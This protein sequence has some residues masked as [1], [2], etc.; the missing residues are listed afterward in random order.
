MPGSLSWRSHLAGRRAHEFGYDDANRAPVVV[1]PGRGVLGMSHK[2]AVQHLDLE[3]EPDIV[4]PD[5]HQIRRAHTALP[6]E[7]LID[8]CGAF[9]V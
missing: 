3:G 8:V 6:P 5:R 4:I 2:A 1:V 7:E 9:A